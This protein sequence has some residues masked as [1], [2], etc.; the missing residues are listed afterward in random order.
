MSGSKTF[1]AK[2]LGRWFGAG[3]DPS[4][5]PMVPPKRLWSM[6]VEEYQSV[7]QEFRRLF[8]EHGHLQ[9]SHRV[10]DVGCGVGRMT[11]PLTEYLS[12]AG[13]YEGFDIEKKGVQWCQ[14]A[15]TSRFPNFRFHHSDV[16][17]RHYNPHGRHQASSYRF[18]YE[19]ELFDFIYLT[20]VFTHLFPADLENYL[21]EIARVL[22][23]G[24]HCF[25]TF[26]IL[27]EES[28][29]L[30]RQHRSTQDFSH[31]LDGCVTTTPNDPEAAIAY[32]EAQ[33][34]ALFARFGLAIEEPI[35]FGS[36]CG[37]TEFLSY[38]D[39]VIA[40]KR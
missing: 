19:D 40:Q 22:K 2:V 18:P 14:E 25:I 30:V 13:G 26:F 4:L 23:R 20:S 32:S 34:R 33:V 38:Q 11:V 35:R 10:L 12:G 17:N 36:W 15:I 24:G 5:E 6:G 9:P 29:A 7:G 16:L 1:V 3:A 21:K 37:R 31:P 8:I 39:I 28:E 27:N